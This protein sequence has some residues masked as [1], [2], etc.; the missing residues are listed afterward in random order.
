MRNDIVTLKFCQNCAKVGCIDDKY[1]KYHIKGYKATYD[2]NEIVKCIECG[3]ELIDCG[4][5]CD[6]YITIVHISLEPSFLESMIRLHRDD[7]VEYQSRMATFRTQIQ[8]TGKQQNSNQPKCPTCSSTNIEKISG[9][10]RGTSVAM[11]GLFSKKIN[12]TFK[13]NNC[14]HTW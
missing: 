9:L 2:K 12:K 6:D 8:Q 5:P 1:F 3:N 14:G 11:W 13:C 4:I 7:I 10:E